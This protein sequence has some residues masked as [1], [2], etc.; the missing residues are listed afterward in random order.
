MGN[1]P[2]CASCAKDEKPE[3]VPTDKQPL[4]RSD[5]KKKRRWSRK[6]KRDKDA[7]STEVTPQQSPAEATTPKRLL[8]E[9]P[10]AR[11]ELYPPGVPSLAH[12]PVQFRPTKPKRLLATSPADPAASPSN[13]SPVVRFQ[14]GDIDV[15]KENEQEGVQL[16]DSTESLDEDTRRRV[17]LADDSGI[18]LGE[19]ERSR[20]WQRVERE[21][22]M[23]IDNSFRE[24]YDIIYV[25]SDGHAVIE[26]PPRLYECTL[27]VIRE[28]QK[29][30]V[31]QNIPPT[32]GT[33]TQL[34]DLRVLLDSEI[35]FHLLFVMVHL[36]SWLRIIRPSKWPSANPVQF[37][38]TNRLSPCR[39]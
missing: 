18:S 36:S 26:Q 23:A 25:A 14:D 27:I 1:T 30:Y 6:S 32:A 13:R 37:R 17:T 28:T 21:R 5:S 22:G 35:F 9:Q 19:A 39:Q 24:Q 10:D 34:L 7:S 16:H 31:I 2:S 3:K 33:D 4:T 29:I 11:R 8:H 38:Y 15:A 12:S 20:V